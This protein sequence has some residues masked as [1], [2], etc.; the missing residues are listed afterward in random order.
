M[1][2]MYEHEDPTSTES[3]KARLEDA[4]NMVAEFAKKHDLPPLDLDLL[5]KHLIVSFILNFLL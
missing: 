1:K 5:K 3:I 2:Y 4:A